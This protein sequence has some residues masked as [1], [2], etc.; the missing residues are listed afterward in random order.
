MKEGTI[1]TVEFTFEGQQFVKNKAQK[2]IAGRVMPS[3]EKSRH[4]IYNMFN[5][6]RV[7]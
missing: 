5:M 2:Q 1:M 4:Q 3:R 7:C 6:N